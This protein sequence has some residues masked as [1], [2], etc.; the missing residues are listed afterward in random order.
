MITSKQILDLLEEWVGSSG[1]RAIPV[2]VNPSSSDY[3]DMQKSLRHRTSTQMK[4]SK[5]R[6]LVDVR[7]KNVYVAD[8]GSI[9]HHDMRDVVNK[10]RK[11]KSSGSIIGG[12]GQVQGGVGEVTSIF[13]NP[14][15]LSSNPLFNKNVFNGDW[16]FADR[17]LKGFTQ[18]LEPI[19]TKYKK[20]SKFTTE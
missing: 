16:T 19:K 15:Y 6:Y 9:V 12:K 7:N 10:Y 14:E 1:S 13:V 8:A 20:L 11:D 3:V 2:Y 5:I 18:L 17:Y 4:I